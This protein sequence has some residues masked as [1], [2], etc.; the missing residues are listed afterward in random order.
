MIYLHL[1]SQKKTNL[2]LLPIA[3]VSFMSLLSHA[4]QVDD[5][6]EVDDDL[7]LNDND[8]FGL[9]EEVELKIVLSYPASAVFATKLDVS[10]T[11]TN[12]QHP[13]LS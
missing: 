6:F 10:R 9:P 13:I 4:V 11:P 2:K 1:V 12:M 8:D 5:D 3:S 7:E